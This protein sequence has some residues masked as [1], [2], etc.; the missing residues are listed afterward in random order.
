MSAQVGSDRAG[1][2]NREIRSNPMTDLIKVPEHKLTAAQIEND[3]PLRLQQIGREITTRLEK[4]DKQT[5]LAEDQ[6]ISVKELVAEAKEL[7]DRSGFKAFQKKFCPTL[8]R[9]RAYAV[10]ALAAGKKTLE[11]DRAQ[12]R[13]RVAKHRAKMSEAGEGKSQPGRQAVGDVH[14][15]M[16]SPRHAAGA[17]HVLSDTGKGDASDAGTKETANSMKSPLAATPKDE[18]SFLFTRVVMQLR[19][20]VGNYKPERFVNTAVPRD[21]LAELGKFLSELAKIKGSDVETAIR[22]INPTLSAEASADEMKAQHLAAEEE[23]A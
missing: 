23:A 13:R 22:G 16:D 19:H 5:Q 4:A 7:C 3:C 18:G 17:A 15:V 2:N 11:Q 14:Y 8:R 1:A 10:L 20:C 6:L 9:S 12:N 21:D